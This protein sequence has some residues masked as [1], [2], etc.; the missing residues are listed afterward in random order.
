MLAGSILAKSPFHATFVKKVSLKRELS[1]HM[2]GFI[3]EKSPFH[4]TYVKK[5][6]LIRELSPDMLSFMKSPFHVNFADE[7]S[8]ITEI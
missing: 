2:Q 8:K 7:I 6:L 5:V 1:L 4:A 3:R